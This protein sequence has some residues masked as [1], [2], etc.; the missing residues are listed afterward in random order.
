MRKIRSRC[1]ESNSSSSHVLVATKKNEYVTEN[2]ITDRTSLEYIY[3]GYK[4]DR[5]WSLSGTRREFGR[6]PFKIL[7]TFKDKLLY[8]IAEYMGYYGFP[9]TGI[10]D[11]EKKIEDIILELFPNVILNFEISDRREVE[12]YLDKEGNEIPYNEL[13]YD[14]Y[15]KDTNKF[16]YTYVSN[17]KTYEAIEDEKDVYDLPDIV[18]I[19]HQSAGTLR[20]FLK[21]KKISL[22]EFLTNKKYRVIID[23]DET[24]TY[25]E[26]LKSG[27]IDANIIEDVYGASKY[28]EEEI[29]KYIKSKGNNNDC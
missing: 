27:D 3:L 25:L 29:K 19:D 5:T 24:E 26:Y 21:D 15:D 20:R 14:H 4:N 1:F 6:G 23:G 18:P 12:I 17:D 13:K 9:P 22:K 7:F 10:D 11:I 8:A 16:I 2:D 28:Y